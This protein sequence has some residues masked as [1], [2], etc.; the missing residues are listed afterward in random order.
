[1]RV[2]AVVLALVC[3]AA[4]PRPGSSEPEVLGK[5]VFPTSCDS[6][7]QGQFERGVAMLH[8][9]WFSEARKVFDAVIRQDPGCAIA[10]WGLA[11]NY[12]GNSLASAPSPKDVAAAA[13][14]L[15]RA[16]AIGAKT[17]RERDWIEAIGAY[18]RDPDKGALND[19]LIAYTKAMEQM[20]QR[21][22]DDFE[23]WTYYALTLQASAPK[24]DKTYANQLKSAEILERLFKQNPE[25]PGVAHYLV[26]AY[27]YPA[28]A[29]KGISIA[30]RYARIAP[31]APHARHMPSHIYS[32]VG[33]GRSPSPRTDRRSRFNPTIITRRTSW[34]TPISSSRRT[35]R[36][37]CWST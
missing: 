23:A 26:H 13:E 6:R 8:S 34:S 9:Y 5:V 19:R 21:Y 7:V 14:G 31:A 4:L 29:S 35:P 33:C 28:L 27:D 37:R 22:P 36:P 11:V 2:G 10:Y 15:D 3:I 1:M 18:Y 24:T 12:L 30:G 16:R 20:T 17:P 32:M 25:H